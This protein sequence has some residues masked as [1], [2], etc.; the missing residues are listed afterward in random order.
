MTAERQNRV[1]V[2]LKVYVLAAGQT[3]R[4]M[5]G[6]SRMAGVMEQLVLDEDFIK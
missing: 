1:V 5:S 3:K 2:L 4:H 6:A